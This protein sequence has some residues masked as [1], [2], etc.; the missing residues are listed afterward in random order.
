MITRKI[1]KDKKG[2]KWLEYG[3][4]NY[5]VKTEDEDTLC[6]TAT[7]LCSK[8]EFSDSYYFLFIDLE[9]D[10]VGTSL[11]LTVLRAKEYFNDRIMSIFGNI[12]WL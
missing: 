1:Y 12:D 10:I 4:R 7:I 6:G 5:I 3:E 2:R 11:G 8:S 9:H